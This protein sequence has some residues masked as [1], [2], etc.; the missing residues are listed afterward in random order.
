[1]GERWLDS[2][3]LGYGVGFQ[4]AARAPQAV[5]QVVSYDRQQNL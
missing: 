1:M 2:A 5:R 3:G 4:P